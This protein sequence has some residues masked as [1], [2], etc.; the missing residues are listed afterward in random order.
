MFL[1][2]EHVAKLYHSF[3]KNSVFWVTILRLCGRDEIPA[4]HGDAVCVHPGEAMAHWV[5]N[6]CPLSANMRESFG[7]HDAL[8]KFKTLPWK[9]V[10]LYSLYNSYTIGN[11]SHGY[12]MK[13][14]RSR[15]WRFPWWAPIF[16]SQFPTNKTVLQVE[17]FLG[18]SYMDTLIL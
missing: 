17:I 1:D 4:M 18:Q 6:R 8:R 13:I 7:K 11:S 16:T 12:C 3:P 10:S 9:L 14:L 5:G 15:D 2:G